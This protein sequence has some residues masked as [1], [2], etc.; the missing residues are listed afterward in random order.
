[1][2]INEERVVVNGDIDIG[3]TIAYPSK[4]KKRPVVLLIMGT[5]DMDRDGNGHGMKMDMY[6]TLSDMFVDFGF[7]CVRYDKRGT[8]E[9][10]G[11]YKTHSVT[12]LVDDSAQVINYVK[13][14]DYV[15]E[16]SVIACGHSEGAMVATLLTK[17]E[18]LE[19]I[20][21]LGGASMCLKSAMMYQNSGI[22]NEYKNKKGLLAWYVR[23]LLPEKKVN[24]QIDDMF[25]RAARAKKDQFFFNG[26]FMNANW[27]KEH[28][29]LTDS[30]FEEML[31]EYD[32]RVL[33]ITGQSDLQADYTA[34]DRIKEFEN[35]VTYTPEKVNHILRDIGDDKNSYLKMRKQYKKTSKDPIHEG[36]KEEIKKFLKR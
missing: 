23:K 20:I 1:M 10:T 13:Q 36:T 9:S 22:I 33:A 2:A 34:L 21:L 3:V 6:K 35:V 4:D 26:V 8:Y 29:E 14:L 17:K 18:K 27:L 31:R 16:N 30:D 24:K 25:D 19:S 15:D 28:G 7:V 12:N 11:N 5:G 32:G